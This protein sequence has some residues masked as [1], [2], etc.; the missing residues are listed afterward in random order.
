MFIFADDDV[1]GDHRWAMELF[2]ALRPLAVKWA[3]QCDI[4]IARNDKL[5]RAMKDS[6]CL[7]I[8]LGLE[9]PKAG[10]LRAAGK[11]YA[12]A[13]KYLSWIRKIQSFDISIWG[14]FIFGFDTDDW[15]HCMNA[16]RFA[17]RADLCMS[18]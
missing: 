2:E 5:L 16:V 12:K 17:Q 7:G 15:R 6:G 11:T 18:C 14:S 4:L 8:I 1:G 3:S 10:T 9:S 13:D